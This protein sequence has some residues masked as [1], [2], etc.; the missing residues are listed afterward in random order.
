MGIVK[1][2]A[3][4]GLLLVVAAAILA[5]IVYQFDMRSAR[6]AWAA[7]AAREATVPCPFSPEMIADL[8]EPARRYLS[9]SIAPGTPIRT[10]VELNM[11]GQF[12]LGDKESHRVLPMSARQVLSPPN[13]FVW[14]PDIGSGVMRIWGSDAL[15]TGEAWTRFWILGLIPV[16]RQSGTADVVRS[17]ATRSIMEAI[18]APASLLPQNG[19]DWEAVGESTAR[20]TL[21][22][23]GEPMSVMMTM[24]ADGRPLTASTVRWSN[25][26]P[27]GVF[28]WQPF[29]GSMLDWATFHGFTIPTRV[30]AGNHYGT[31]DYFPF[32]RAEIVSAQY[33]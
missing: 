7:L 23:G 18:W 5:Q 32:F 25:A 12:A 15:V 14:I 8:P 24:A 1:I 4:A 29:G 33:L 3:V 9:Y 11:R 30:E 17:A 16:A 28:R 6:Q 19:A 13:G 31:E 20:V 10:T 21:R 26:N 27:D 2:I 22:V